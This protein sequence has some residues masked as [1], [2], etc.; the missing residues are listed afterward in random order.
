MAQ[1][2]APARARA[3]MDAQL[4]GDIPRRARQTHQESGQNPVGE[5]L[6]AS[7]EQRLRQSVERPSTA[8]AAGAFESRPIMVHALGADRVA[9]TPGTVE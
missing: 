5:R 4:S 6:L 2:P 3:D 8:Y 9:V 7:G 1:P